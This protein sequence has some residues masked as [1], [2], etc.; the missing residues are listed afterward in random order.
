ME[1]SKRDSCDAWCIVESKCMVTNFII[2]PQDG[3]DTDTIT[4]Y[5]NRRPGNLILKATAS[6]SATVMDRN[7]EIFTRGI[8][9]HDWRK[10]TSY[11][12]GGSMPFMLFEWNEEISISTIRIQLAGYEPD[13]PSEETEIRLGSTVQWLDLLTSLNLNSLETLTTLN[14]WNGESLSSILPKK[15]NSWLS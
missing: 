12:N 13:F 10:T 2:S 7:A 14:P 9:N 1:C 15:S 11:I 5:T 8:Y 3:P 4:C 6:N